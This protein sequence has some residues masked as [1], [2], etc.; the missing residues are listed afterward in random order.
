MSRRW[1]IATAVGLTGVALLACLALLLVSISS[2]RSPGPGWLSLLNRP[3][4]EDLAREMGMC[5]AM[6]QPGRDLRVHAFRDTPRGGRFVLFS[7][8][9]PPSEGQQGEQLSFGYNLREG[10]S[11]SGGIGPSPSIV[12]LRSAAYDV[13]GVQSETG[14][15]NYVGGRITDARV[16]T[17]Q[18]TFDDG[19]T[20]SDDARDGVFGLIDT[21]SSGPC[22]VRFLDAGGKEL[23]RASLADTA[24]EDVGVHMAPR[25]G[26]SGWTGSRAT[27]QSCARQSAPT[28]PPA[29]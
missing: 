5:G 1:L 13:G 24:P 7:V 20:L 8:L 15:Y 28:M 4:P 11:G 12:P 27:A 25:G 21:G 10:S 26:S 22:E 16:A 9:C 19:Q 18:G 17:V 6:G 29:R 23:E 2:P 3:S 14:R